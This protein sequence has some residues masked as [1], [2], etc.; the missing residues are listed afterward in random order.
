MDKQVAKLNRNFNADYHVF[1]GAGDNDQ[2][3]SSPVV[4]QL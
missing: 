2:L 3:V 4:L 1:D